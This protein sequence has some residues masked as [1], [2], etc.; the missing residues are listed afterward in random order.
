[1]INKCLICFSLGF[2]CYYPVKTMLTRQ[3]T[4]TQQFSNKKSL[5]SASKKAD[6][7][8]DSPLQPA[9]TKQFSQQ[10]SLRS[11]SAKSKTVVQIEVTETP[12]VEISASVSVSPPVAKRVRSEKKKV[13]TVKRTTRATKRSSLNT[14]I[15]ECFEK[16]KTKRSKVIESVENITLSEVVCTTKTPRVEEKA[17][18]GV[19]KDSDNTPKA[20]TLNKTPSLSHKIGKVFNPNL[21][22]PI[23]YETLLSQ[24]VA[25]DRCISLLDNRGE[26]VTYSKLKSAI[27]EGTKRHDLTI[28]YINFY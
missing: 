3:R 26:T 16:A 1:M 27:E 28:S 14:S 25:A 7:Q 22:L 2:F 12:V 23:A 18:L 21:K 15:E 11:A 10:K 24:F 19:L 5:R 9:I 20:E 6:L 8:T 4:I 17:K 13:S